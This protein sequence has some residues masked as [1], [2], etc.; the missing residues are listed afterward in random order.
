MPREK[1]QNPI[2]SSRRNRHMGAL[3]LQLF[4][5]EHFLLSTIQPSSLRYE[6]D[7]EKLLQTLRYQV[8]RHGAAEM[9]R[10]FLVDSLILRENGEKGTENSPPLFPYAMHPSHPLHGLSAGS[11]HSRKAGLL[12][13]CPLCVTSQL[14]SSP[15]ALPLIKASFPAF[16]SQY[17][18]SALSRQ[19]STSSGVNLSGS[20]LYQATYP[21]PDPRQFHCISIGKSGVS[22]AST[23]VNFCHTFL[24]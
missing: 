9:P 11:C 7:K 8:K 24:F 6:T 14:H 4:K 1:A 3:A 22:D 19:H 16:S 20:G 13:F 10:S 23:E 5:Q 15:P 21:V 2:E 12:C 17:C 18:H